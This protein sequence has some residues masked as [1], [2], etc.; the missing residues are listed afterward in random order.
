M[1]GAPRDG[2][3][4][5]ALLED[6]GLLLKPPDVCDDLGEIVPGDIWDL[7]HVA[8]LPVMGAHPHLRCAIE[9]AIRVMVGFVDLV[10]ERRTDGG[11]LG[12]DAVARRATA[13]E[14]G[15]AFAE[16]GG[17]LDGRQCASRQGAPRP[18]QRRGPLQRLLKRASPL[19][20]AGGALTAGALAAAAWVTAR[21]KA[22]VT[23]AG[24]SINALS[25]PSAFPLPWR[26]L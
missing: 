18:Q 16:G 12:A 26:S 7:R 5:G 19:L 10:E 25:S 8:E 6:A 23:A 14:E 22:S 3:G 1:E 21:H 17:R 2:R 13:V 11:P 15:L 9:G 4:R 20:R 24:S